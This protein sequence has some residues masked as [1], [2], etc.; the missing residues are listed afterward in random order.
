MVCIC[1]FAFKRLF[2]LPAAS[3]SLV[4][5]KAP[6]AILE[7]QLQVRIPRIF[8]WFSADAF[9]R[10]GHR[11]FPFVFRNCSSILLLG[12]IR[13]VAGSILDSVAFVFTSVFR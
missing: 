4:N 13:P 7:H 12:R 3:R 2:Y 11:A 8:K 9:T 6:E 10:V 1:V 5:W